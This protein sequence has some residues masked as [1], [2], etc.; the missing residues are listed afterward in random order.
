MSKIATSYPLML[1]IVAPCLDKLDGNQISC[2]FMHCPFYAE[3]NEEKLGFVMDIELFRLLS[4]CPATSSRFGFCRGLASS[5][6]VWRC[7]FLMSFC[8]MT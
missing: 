8:Q 2:C 7:L 1:E 5:P 6:N 4:F 3:G